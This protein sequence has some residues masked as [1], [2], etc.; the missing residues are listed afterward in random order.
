[1]VLK[2]TKIYIYV[3]FIRS[4][5]FRRQ[6]V[7]K[8]KA[9]NKKKISGVSKKSVPVAAGISAYNSGGSL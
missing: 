4:G 1:V 6:N 5:C 7:F 9:R 8:P 2:I 3:L